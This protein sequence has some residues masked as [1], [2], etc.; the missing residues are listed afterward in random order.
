MTDPSRTSSPVCRTIRNTCDHLTTSPSQ[1]YLCRRGLQA[2]TSLCQQFSSP[3]P[4][5]S[6]YAGFGY[7]QSLAPLR[8]CAH[9]F[10]N[11]CH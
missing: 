6:G 11:F 8:F 1:Y 2:V 9:V 5:N 7:S 3:V 10:H 4:G